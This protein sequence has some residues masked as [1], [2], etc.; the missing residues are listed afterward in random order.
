LPPLNGFVSEWLVYM[1]LLRASLTFDASILVA[2]VVPV[3]ALVGALALAC[4]VKVYGA[5]FLGSPRTP[6][7]ARAHESPATMRGPMLLL[8][9][10]CIVI[11]LGPALV[12]PILD[13]AVASGCPEMDLSPFRLSLIIPVKAISLMAALLL[14]GAGAAA[15]VLFARRQPAPR[16]CT[17]DCG[18]ARPTARMQVTASSFAQFINGLFGWVLRPHT[19]HPRLAGLF[20]AAAAMHSH[21]D[22]PVLDRMLLPAGRRTERLFNWFHRFQQGLIQNYVLYILITLLLMLC[23][24]ISFKDILVRL[25]AR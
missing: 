13:Q 19:R 23:T 9:A 20:P 3:L 22:E 4:F 24:L 11:G 5:V 12:G 25:F 17:W 14:A 10:C 2:F 1:G 18:Y 6:L 16:V 8:A 15:L 7:S 21:V